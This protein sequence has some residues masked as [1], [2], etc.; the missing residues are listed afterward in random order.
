[1]GKP[2]GPEKAILFS[3]LLYHNED[4]CQK[5]LKELEK[6]LGPVEFVTGPLLWEYTQFYRDELGWP[7][8]RRFVLFD[9][10]IDPSDIVDIKLQSN[11]LEEL[12]S[13]NGKRTVNID[14]GYLTLSKL[15]LATTKNYTH[16][17]Y[18]GKGIY[19]EVTLYY[20]K[21]RFVE[22]QFTYRDYQSPEYKATFERMREFLKQKIQG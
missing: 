20:I 10:L 12:L 19:A 21:G 11:A 17:I 9:R 8:Y 13:V 14:P 22:H 18:L 6:A 7:I 4:A 1:M 5:A 3:G 2:K 15:V 16:R